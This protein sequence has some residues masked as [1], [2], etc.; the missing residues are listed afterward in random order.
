MTLI[1]IGFLSTTV[2]QYNHSNC[3]YYYSYYRITYYI[4]IWS[5][6]TPLWYYYSNGIVTTHELTTVTAVSL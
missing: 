2:T 1:N 3:S 6:V 5:D 4:I